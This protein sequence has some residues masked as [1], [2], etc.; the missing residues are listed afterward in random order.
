MVGVDIVEIARIKNA[1]KNGAFMQKTFTP[2]E[3]EYATKKLEPEQ[4]YAGIYAVKEAMAKALKTD[5]MQTIRE[6]EVRHDEKGAPYAVL[7]GKTLEA[8]LGYKVEISISH[9]GGYAVAVV[10]GERV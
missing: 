1:T 2:Y 10:M 3:I 5:L 6:T 4:T 7:S 8:S 9:D